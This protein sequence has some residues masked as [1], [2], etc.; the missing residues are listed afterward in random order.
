LPTYQGKALIDTPPQQR[1]LPQ[2]IFR[3]GKGKTLPG[4]E[5]LG[6]ELSPLKTRS[7]RKKLAQQTLQSSESD[8][9]STESGPLRAMKALAREK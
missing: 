5:G 6:I 8:P 4:Q 9:P 7:S 3:L 1:R 2:R